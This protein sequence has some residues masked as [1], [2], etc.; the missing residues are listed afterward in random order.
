M[1]WLLKRC[2]ENIPISLHEIV[3]QFNEL[4]GNLYIAELR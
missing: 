4:N 2:L 1:R 3:Y